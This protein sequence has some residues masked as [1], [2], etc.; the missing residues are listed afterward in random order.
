MPPAL[1]MF[2][3]VFAR[4]CERLKK[5]DFDLWITPHTL[6]HTYAVYMLNQLIRHTLDT[7]V[8]IGR[9][10]QRLSDNTYRRVIADPL[11]TLQK[12][13]GH[14][15]ITSTYKYLTYLEEAEEL[16][17]QAIGSWGDLV[18]SPDL[19]LIEASA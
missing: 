15:S 18:G 9:E 4:A 6:R 17:D 11:R 5:F 19:N 3:A 13:L 12:L 7:D 16:V 14:A 10:K 2:E 1:N 8:G